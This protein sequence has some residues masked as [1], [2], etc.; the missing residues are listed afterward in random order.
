MLTK[1]SHYLSFSKIVIFYSIFTHI[2]YLLIVRAKHYKVWIVAVCKT[3]EI[4]CVLTFLLLTT[5]TRSLATEFSLILS[6]C[7]CQLGNWSVYLLKCFWRI[8]A[9]RIYISTKIFDK[10][11]IPI[12]KYLPINC[13]VNNYNCLPVHIIYWYNH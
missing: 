7:I 1:F 4:P 9:I 2:L 8:S 10:S 13:N 3:A 5:F 11:I 6:T 12:W